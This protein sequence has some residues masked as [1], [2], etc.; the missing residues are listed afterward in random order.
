MFA[1]DSEYPRRPWLMTPITDD[2]EGTPE[3]KYPWDRTLHYTPERRA[4]ITMACRVLH[5]LALDLKCN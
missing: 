5:N 4:T 2:A 3:A 1:G